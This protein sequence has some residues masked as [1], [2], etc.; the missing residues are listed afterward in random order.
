MTSATRSTRSLPEQVDDHSTSPEF[1]GSMVQ[2]GNVSVP[3]LH[4]ARLFTQATSLELAGYNPARHR[5]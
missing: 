4:H 2:S 5:Q 3:Q 1:H